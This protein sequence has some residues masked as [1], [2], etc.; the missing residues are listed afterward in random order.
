M[1]RFLCHWWV[2]GA[3][4]VFLFG[5]A[6]TLADFTIMP[7]GDSVT[8]GSGNFGQGVPGGYRT[9]L[10]TD[11]LQAGYSFTFVGTQTANPSPLLSQVGQTHHEGHPGYMISQTANNL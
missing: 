1:R 2:L 4:A 10:Y 9:R 3:L 5:K 6:A 8:F 11:L 7:L